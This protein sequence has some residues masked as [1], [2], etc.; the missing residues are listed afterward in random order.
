M[1][2][3]VVRLSAPAVVANKPSFQGT[4]HRTL[5]IAFKAGKSLNIPL[6]VSAVT[7]AEFLNHHS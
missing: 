1:G 7:V 4:C 2:A 6:S 3:A 5:E